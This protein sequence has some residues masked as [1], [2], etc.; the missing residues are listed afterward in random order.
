MNRKDLADSVLLGLWIA[1]GI[2]G[3]LFAAALLFDLGTSLVM[4]LTRPFSLSFTGGMLS[5]HIAHPLQLYPPADPVPHPT[6]YPPV[7][8]FLGHAVPVNPAIIAG[9]IVNWVAIAA[10]TTMLA[11]HG[12]RYSGRYSVAALVGAVFILAPT[13][14]GPTVILRVDHLGLAFT[15]AAI[16]G[17]TRGWP[18][19]S[20]ISLSVAAGFSK[21]PYAILSIGSIGA[22]CLVTGKRRTAAKYVAGS[23]GV[24][25][26]LLGILM[27]LTDGRA[28]THLVYYN[29]VIPWYPDVFLAQT[30]TFLLK[31]G[32]TIA[33]AGG[34]LAASG[35]DRWKDPI[36]WLF[37]LGF[38]VVVTTLG[39]EGSWI[40]YFY[41]ALAAATALIG[42][43]ISQVEIRTT[44]PTRR[45]A[46]ITTV[47]V[48]LSVQLGTFTLID[49]RPEKPLHAQQEVHDYLQQADGLV[50][51]EDPSIVPGP[52]NPVA[53]F[54]VMGLVE[55]GAIDG[56]PL[57]QALRCGRY[58]YVVT[59]ISVQPEG[60]EYR[61]W[62][63]AQLTAIE[64]HYQRVKTESAYSVY[65]YEGEK[66]CG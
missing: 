7:L 34:V 43:A 58:E 21:Q 41:P 46:A 56:D 28:W 36:P 31:H 25:L 5:W 33:I 52:Q 11:H 65:R 47:I 8:F 44:M 27:V 55:S 6:I 49:E 42:A 60:H 53:V 10:S 48:L 26:V 40:G 66:S 59:W 9:R 24:G 23:A 61:R 45:Q 37:V 18:L 22:A 17:Y 29:R 1:S 14:S 38:V 39:R 2:M 30:Y 57:S 16:T 12:Y 13:V 54:V 50:L 3:S 63:K 35:R 20:L 15:L 51:S 62:T 32:V 64:Q 4:T 19:W